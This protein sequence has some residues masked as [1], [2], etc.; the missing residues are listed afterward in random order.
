M[1]LDDGDPVEYEITVMD[2][3]L[4]D[5]V[6]DFEVNGEAKVKATPSYGPQG[7]QVTV[8]AWNFTRVSG[9]EVKVTLGGQGAKTFKT[10]ASGYFKGTYTIPAVASI[11]QDLVAKTV[12]IDGKNHNVTATSTVRVGVM[13]AIITP[14]IA[15]SGK[16]VS[17]TGVGFTAGEEV[18]AYLDDDEWFT[19]GTVETDGTFAENPNVP[20]ME[21]GVYDVKIVDEDTEIEVLISLTVTDK[22]MLVLSPSKAPN[23]YN[24]T[25]EGSYFA[26]IEAGD[27]ASLEFI[28]YNATSEWLLEVTYGG[29]AVD[30]EADADWDDGYFIGY[31]KVPNEDSIG[32]GTYTLNVTDG[33]GMFAQVTF[34]VVPKTTTITPRK[35]T[36]RIGET[37]AFNVQSSFIQ[38]NAYIKIFD[39]SG[40][41]YWKTDPFAELEW[42]KVGEVQ[43]YPF[44]QQTAGGNAMILLEDAPLGSYTWKWY[45]ADDDVLDQ[46]VFTVAAAPSD[47]LAEQVEDLNE[48]MADLSDEISTV[49]DAVAGVKS[50]VNSAIAAANAAVEAANAAVDAVNAA[51]AQSG[52]AAQAAQNAADAAAEAQEAASGLTTLVYGAIGA[53][54]VAALAAIVSLM[55]ISRRIAG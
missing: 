4:T 54:L 36:F 24:V 30:L 40:D 43:V 2:E 15:A 23:T 44:Y 38:E 33:M 26:E 11:D 53:S 28:L 22:T 49:S 50:D 37:V 9:T 34:Q 8:E 14:G 39:P 55:Q 3:D 25:V 27:D 12:D 51:A 13:L 41:Q 1:P 52:E 32:L 7:T 18:T 45:D 29:T 5:A 16:K 31:F 20:T 21:P 42:T 10:D 48:A 47:I 46:G 19:V 17:V 35:A 6:A